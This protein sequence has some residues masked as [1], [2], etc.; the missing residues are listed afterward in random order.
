MPITKVEGENRDHRVFLYALSTCGWCKKTKQFLNDN[1]V[2]YEYLDVDTAGK[3]E[4][5]EAIKELRARKAPL[6]FPIIVVDGERLIV[7][8]RV[9]ELRE[10]LSL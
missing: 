6:G 3:E 5:E 2:E 1:G 9:D 7:G 10:A 4:K 8:Y